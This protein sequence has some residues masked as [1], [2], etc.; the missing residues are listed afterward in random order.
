MWFLNQG[1]AGLNTASILFLIAA[2]FALVYGVLHILNFAHGSFYLIGAY[3]CYT[4]VHQFGSSPVGFLLSLIL[5]P[6]VI[7]LVSLVVEVF[8]LR[9]VYGRHIL[10]QF[11]LTLGLVYLFSDLMRLVWGT[12]AYSLRRPAFLAGSLDLGGAMIPVYSLFTLGV[13]CLAGI[14]LWVL[15]HKTMFGKR[16]RALHQD[17]EMAAMLGMNVPKLRSS[18]FVLGSYLAGVGGAVAAGA[19]TIF[20]GLDVEFAII[21]Y[22]VITIGGVG[23]A[24]GPLVGALLI[25]LAEAFGI[26][27]LPQLAV[28][29]MYMLLVIVLI[30]RPWG[31]VGKAPLR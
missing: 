28:I 24:A 20:P 3:V 9:Y 1:L 6:L 14:L 10:Y 30:A 22:V 5:S 23:G 4:F 29:F 17:E 31:L 18:V 16:V 26:L 15:L 2:G 8:L 13:A 7:A 19:Q 11:A 25:G 21:A 12:R 27:V